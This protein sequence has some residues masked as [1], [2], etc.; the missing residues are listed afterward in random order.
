LDSPTLL[1]PGGDPEQRW[2]KQI[3]TFLGLILGTIVLTF[4][5]FASSL[6]ITIV[7]SAFLA[8]LVD[9][10]V[11]RVAKIGLGR[12]LASG[13]VVLCLLLLAGTL[14]YVLY[15][16]ASAFADEFPSYQYR[17]QQALAPLVSKFERFEKNAQS[18]TPLV[19]G[20]KR[21]TEVT[22]RGAPTNWPSFLVRGVGSISGV[23]IM[24][25][26]LPFMVF[27]MLARKD[28]MNVRLVN[29]FGGR[30]DVPKFVSNL[31]GM[32]RGFVLGNLIVG[33]IMAAGTSV[34]F[35]V[36]G[37]KGAVTL[38]IVS[39][40]LN[41]IPFLGL[42]LAAA[43]PL[44]AALLQFNTI[45]PFVTIAILVV[46]FHLIAANFLIPKLIG[47]R[48]LVGPVA[49]TVGMLFWGWLWGFMGLLLAVPLTAFVK[50]IADS[51]PSLIHL[52]NLLTEDP[53]PIP[54]LSRFGEY[55]IQRV[56]PYLKGRTSQK[57]NDNPLP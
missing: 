38:G 13:L 40:F 10:L 32:I 23:L 41:L 53:H 34:V 54:R 3:A 46:L 42:L 1:K 15:N 36:L 43:V 26:V 52:S 51:R 31:S 35:L 18:V 29:M 9:P 55:A 39:A 49:V 48:L 44:A 16:R 50:L 2:L 6:C 47:S 22:V 25:G 5:F 30:I 12:V 8:I 21:V 20:S 45:G 33:S 17:I 37:M 4:C 19:E 24:G 27:F 57:P 28:Q 14:S 7:L 56:K 11:V